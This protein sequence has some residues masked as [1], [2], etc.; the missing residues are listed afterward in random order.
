MC[1]HGFR[2]SSDSF[3]LFELKVPSLFDSDSLA[4]RSGT[5]KSFVARRTFEA[6][7][8]QERRVSEADLKEKI[9]L[10]SASVG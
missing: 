1:D 3:S 9:G 2:G 8:K 10:S 7:F 4:H 5:R 6:D